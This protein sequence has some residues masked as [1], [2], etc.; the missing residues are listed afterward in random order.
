MNATELER[1]KKHD[2]EMDEFIKRINPYK[3]AEQPY[4]FDF[5]GYSKYIRDHNLKDKD[6]TDEIMNMFKS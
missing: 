4:K 1:I 2:E 5:H 6:I 3:S